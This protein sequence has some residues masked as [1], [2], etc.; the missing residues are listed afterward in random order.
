ML[1][2]WNA[3]VERVKQ[4][5]RTA[6]PLEAATVALIVGALIGYAI[7]ADTGQRRYNSLIDGV[8]ED[9]RQFCFDIETWAKANPRDAQVLFDKTSGNTWWICDEAWNYRHGGNTYPTPTPLQLK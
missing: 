4:R 8:N 7:A 6:T 9:V 1:R 5:L 3:L 2:S